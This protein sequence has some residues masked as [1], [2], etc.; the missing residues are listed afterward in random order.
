MSVWVTMSTSGPPQAAGMGR[1]NAPAERRAPAVVALSRRRRSFSAVSSRSSGPRATALARISGPFT[2][3]PS[4]GRL[5]SR[6]QV[7]ATARKA[8]DPTGG[9]SLMRGTPGTTA[10]P[11]SIRA[12][13]QG[14]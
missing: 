11:A 3:L 12:D 13:R 10:W 6:A 2:G 14:A 1:R 5:Q 7:S 8:L 4:R 9:P